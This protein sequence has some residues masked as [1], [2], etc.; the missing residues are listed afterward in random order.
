MS[1]P[2]KA[3]YRKFKEGYKGILE[4]DRAYMWAATGNSK[5]KLRRDIYPGTSVNDLPENDNSSEPTKSVPYR[6]TKHTY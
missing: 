4:S 6:S 1:K 2:T 5:Y 3:G